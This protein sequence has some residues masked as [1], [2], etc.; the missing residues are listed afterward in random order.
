MPAGQQTPQMKRLNLDVKN[1]YTNYQTN[2]QQQLEGRGVVIWQHNLAVFFLQ[3]Y[4]EI[5]KSSNIQH[6]PFAIYYDISVDYENVTVTVNNKTQDIR[7]PYFVHMTTQDKVE[8]NILAILVLATLYK[9]TIL[10]KL[11]L[12][13]KQ[14]QWS[15]VIKAL[16][17]D[18][19]LHQQIIDEA[20]NALD[21]AIRESISHIKDKINKFKGNVTNEQQKKQFMNEVSDIIRQKINISN[22]IISDTYEKLMKKKKSNTNYKRKVATKI[23]LTS[24][25][26]AASAAG[27]IAGFATGVGAAAGALSVIGLARSIASLASVIA[28]T[29]LDAEELERRVILGLANYYEKSLAD[30]QQAMVSGQVHV[31]PAKRTRL[32][33]SEVAKTT[34]ASFVGDFAKVARNISYGFSRAKKNKQHTMV[35]EK[36]VYGA[37]V[38]VKSLEEDCDLWTSKLNRLEIKAHHLAKKINSMMQTCQQLQNAYQNQPKNNNKVTSKNTSRNDYRIN[39]NVTIAHVNEVVGN[40]AF[41]LAINKLLEQLNELLEHIHTLMKRVRHGFTVQ[42]KAKDCINMLKHSLSKHVRRY[43]KTMPT[44]VNMAMAASSAAVNIHDAIVQTITLATQ[45]T[46]STVETAE[47]VENV[48]GYADALLLGLGLDT[49]QEVTDNVIGD[50]Y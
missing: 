43:E 50:T 4:K 44:A 7:R 34:A 39:S 24:L 40:A 33:A 20:N 21:S 14:P 12:D 49:T 45:A 13:T 3:K 11:D 48:Y 37:F 8:K 10:L 36:K 30:M 35:G 32:N 17:E 22:T 9:K 18:P 1:I 2:L 31:N 16:E 15:N 46:S 25:G 27:T 42:Q 41:V 5:T 47:I 38:N 26:T 29:A 23:V 28:D 6:D 19:V